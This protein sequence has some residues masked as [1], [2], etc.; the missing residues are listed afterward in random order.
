M[1]GNNT[2]EEDVNGIG[3]AKSFLNERLFAWLMSQKV[4]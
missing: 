1:Y 2:S 4:Y 3:A